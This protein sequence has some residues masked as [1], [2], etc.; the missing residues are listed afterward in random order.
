MQ[1]GLLARG[2]I[3]RRIMHR[4]FPWKSYAIMPATEKPRVALLVRRLIPTAGGLEFRAHDL[5]VALADRGH[6][7]RVLTTGASKSRSRISRRRGAL[8]KAER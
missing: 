7:I 8:E 1:I 2:Q 6:H 4:I 3:F 5:A